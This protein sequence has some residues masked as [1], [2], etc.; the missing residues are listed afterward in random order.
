[1]LIREN[2][3]LQYLDFL[4][5]DKIKT[6]YDVGARRGESALKFKQFADNIISF[7]PNSDEFKYL[8]KLEGVHVIKKAASNVN[9][10]AF[11]NTEYG[12]GQCFVTCKETRMPIECVTIDSLN[13]TA[14]DMIKID[15]ENHEMKVLLGA[16]ETIKKYLPHLVIA[17]YHTIHQC[18]EVHKFIHNN[19]GDKYIFECANYSNGNP[20]ETILYCIRK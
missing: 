2:H 3:H 16:F 5:L 4:P 11:L 1:M 15:T 7:E 10:K 18:F 19:F 14:P 8:D 12:T 9:G 20:Y 17:C 13:L 6:V